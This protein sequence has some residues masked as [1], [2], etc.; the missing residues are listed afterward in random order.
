MEQFAEVR[1][2][3]L[4]HAVETGCPVG[5][6]KVGEAFFICGRSDEGAMGCIGGNVS[7][8]RRVISLRLLDP[9]K[10]CF[11]EQIRTVATRLDE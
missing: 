2:D 10:R 6:T 5:E 8:E 4:D 1:V 9:S 7:K 11:E 3:V